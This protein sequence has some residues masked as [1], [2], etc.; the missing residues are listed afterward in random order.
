MMYSPDSH[1][2]LY[3][4]WSKEPV[5]EALAFFEPGKVVPGFK[6]TTN[7]GKQQLQ[8][9]TDDKLKFYDGW[10]AFLKEGLCR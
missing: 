8:K 3:L 9:G 6:F 10:G 1:G 7:H 4:Q 5:Q 2:T